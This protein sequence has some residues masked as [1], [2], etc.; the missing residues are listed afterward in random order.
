MFYAHEGPA[1]DN[2]F[3]LGIDNKPVRVFRGFDTKSQRLAYRAL[4][5]RNGNSLLDCRRE[6]VSHYLGRDFRAFLT[7][8]RDCY[9][10][11]AAST[12]NHPGFEQAGGVL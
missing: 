3:T 5:Y 9:L 1:T 11:L 7:R 12:Y 10:C 8:T 4:A 2:A 6:R